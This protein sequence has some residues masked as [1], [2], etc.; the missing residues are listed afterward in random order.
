MLVKTVNTDPRF[1]ENTYEFTNIS[2]DEPDPVLFRI[3]S[4]YTVVDMGAARRP[5]GGQ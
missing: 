1:G 3:P 4:G 2:R 5:A